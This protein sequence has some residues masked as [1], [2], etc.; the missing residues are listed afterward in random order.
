MPFSHPFDQFTDSE[1][2][3]TS[4]L[5]KDHYSSNLHFVQID[6]VEPPKSDVLK[7]LKAK[8][9]NESILPSVPRVSFAYFYKD[10]LLYKA[11][12]NLVEAHIITSVALPEGVVGPALPEDMMEIEEICLAH[13]TVKKEVEKLQLPPGY[14]IRADP[15]IY[16]TDDPNEKRPLVQCYMYLKSQ[17]HPESNHYSLPLFFS[18]VFELLTQKFV[19]MDYLPSGYDNKSLKTHPW[20]PVESCEYYP[21]LKKEKVER[22]LAPLIIT[23]PEGPGFKIEGSK[24]YWQDW[25]FHVTPNVREGFAIHDVKFKNRSLFYRISLS[26]MVVP[27]SKIG[28]GPCHRKQAFDLGDCGFGTNANHLHLGCDCLGVIKYF[29]CI[30]TNKEGEPILLPNTVCL[31]EQDAGLLYKHV[32][33][34]TNAPVAA[35]RREF[36]VQSIATVA[37]YEYI[38]NYIFDQA[39]SINVQV[40]AT[41]IL[42]TTPIEENI[43][44][45]YGTIVAPNCLAPFHQHLL[46]FRFDPRLDGDKNTVV[47]DDVVPLDPND[48]VNNKYKVAFVTKTNYVEKAGHIDTNPYASRSVKI[49]NENVINPITKKPVGY[50]IDMPAKQMILADKESYNVKRAKFA[51]KQFWVTKYRD[52]EL[53]AAGEFTNQS[54]TDTGIAKW[55]N[56]KDDVRNEDCVIWCTLALTHIPRPEDFPVMPVDMLQFTILPVGFFERNPALDVPQSNNSFNKS[57]LVEDTGSNLKSCCK[58]SL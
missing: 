57:V 52:G 53:Y 15:W 30:R 36:V 45:P 41:G 58:T 55:A 11:L 4:K 2:R 34:R 49:I 35:R 23:Q 44:V 43:T 51:T 33:Y 17:P 9:A 39:G 5:L 42:S 1:M 46:S 3:L 6:L 7:Y 25:E 14:E 31:H 20:K 40:R 21:G 47:Y 10:G 37:N 54:Q 26:E 32:N 29:D 22:P 48:E 18:P 28:D 50:K 12:I 38:V 27:Y 24:I 8:A 19:R 56:G 16:G 13:E